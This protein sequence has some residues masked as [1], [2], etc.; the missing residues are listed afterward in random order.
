MSHIKSIDI[1]KKCHQFWS[2]M[3]PI[4]E[5]RHC[6][7]C[8]KAVINFTAMTD[9]EIINYLSR[10]DNV[11]G[12]FINNQIDQLN[13]NI[14]TP[15]KHLAFFKNYKFA[16]L[17]A[18]IMIFNKTE[19]KPKEPQQFMQ[20][21]PIIKSSVNTIDS[22]QYIK[23]RGIV[24]DE[25]GGR[26]QGANVSIRGTNLATITNSKGYFELTVLQ[27]ANYQLEFKFIGHQT[28]DVP[29]LP[30]KK[31]KYRIT[32]KDQVFSMGEVI[33]TKRN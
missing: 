1:P 20:F 30:D 24:T 22:T 25:N 33:V 13:Q 2:D 4:N 28:I 15:K 26:I 14:I 3:S 29:V 11:C 19:A 16:A 18:G 6:E 12:R 21:K 9:S 31:S 10:N 5:G 32:L 7:N 23:V 17:L 27:D 8:N